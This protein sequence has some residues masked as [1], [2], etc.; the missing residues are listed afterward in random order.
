MD[1]D[2]KRAV[3]GKRRLT[4]R[5]MVCAG[6][7][8]SVPRRHHRQR[9]CPECSTQ[10]V[11]ANRKV[12]LKR[13]YQENKVQQRKRNAA[14][15]KNNPE[16]SRTLARKHQSTDAFR[17]YRNEWQRNRRAVS[18]QYVINDRIGSGIYESLKERKAGRAW[19]ALVGYT[20][21]DL[22][23]HLER[24]FAKG[25]SWENRSD[26]DIDHIIPRSAFS[27]NSAEDAE[28]KAC[29][30]LTNLRPLWSAVNQSKHA[31]RVLL[32]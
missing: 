1:R 21:G 17:A 29:W 26:W 16:K 14:W 19:E 11:I 18:A 24:Q 6:C 4:P 31:R 2:A 7:S 12:A 28:F 32:L 25:M 8:Q 30:A 20:L 9:Y 13:W 15:H 22:M 5:E 27:F 10:V 3:H 23:V